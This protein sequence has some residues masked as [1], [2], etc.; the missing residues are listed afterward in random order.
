M[1]GKG[2]SI[3]HTL[4][5]MQ[6]GWNQEK[7]AEVVYSQNLVGND[8]KEISKE[9][10]RIQEL[11]HNCNRNTLSFVLSPTIEDG[12]LLKGMETEKLVK[13]F[14]QELQLGERQ[15]IA[16]VHRD[17]EHAHIHLY[18]NRIDFEGKA[19]NDSFIGKQSQ[20]AA[21]KVAEINGLT[22]V[23]QVQQEISFNTSELRKEIH[24]RHELTLKHMQP[25]N[26]KEYVEGM[27]A[28][29][30]KLEPF[31]NRQGELQ[32]YRY[33]FD[34]QNFKGSEV[35]RSMSLGNLGKTLLKE[36]KLGVHVPD[37]KKLRALSGGMNLPATIAKK[38]V[39]TVIK[40]TID[41]GIGF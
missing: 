34:G 27:R 9:F 23:K 3:S 11:N 25:K 16:F 31:I 5:S 2:K 28:N 20:K 21:E 33:H 39:K 35:H 12:R 26:L 40:K 14:M 37:I 36:H 8:P 29:G 17:K 32:G 13:D 15:A 7:D 6:Y 1:I 19:Y 24:R 30:V 10:Q 41:Q 18:V 22:T 4:A 38:I